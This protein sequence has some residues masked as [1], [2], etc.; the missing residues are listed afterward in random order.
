VSPVQRD[1]SVGTCFCA[2]DCP[3]PSHPPR[4]YAIQHKTAAGVPF[5][6]LLAAHLYK[7]G[8]ASISDCLWLPETRHCEAGSSTNLQKVVPIIKPDEFAYDMIFTYAP[9]VGGAQ[10]WGLTTAWHRSQWPS[11]AQ[12]SFDCARVMELIPIAVG[13][14]PI[15][16]SPVPHW[17]CDQV[18]FREWADNNSLFP[19]AT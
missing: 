10:K 12:S 13:G 16:I 6:C 18:Q 2:A 4:N 11:P 5:A 8:V 14:R 19:D 17:L 15:I 1:N 7:S 3:Y 9:M